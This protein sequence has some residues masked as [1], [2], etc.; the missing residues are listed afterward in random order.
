MACS[1]EN[2]ISDNCACG[3]IVIAR[4]CISRDKH[5]IQRLDYL[6]VIENKF[7][8]FVVIKINDNNNNNNFFSDRLNFEK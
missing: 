6:I 8:R 3:R 7:I 5:V 1:F 4:Y 2:I